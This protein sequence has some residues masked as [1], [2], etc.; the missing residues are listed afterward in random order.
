MSSRRTARYGR[1][2]LT[3]E[4]YRLLS[5]AAQVSWTSG[6]VGEFQG[7]VTVGGEHV[8]NSP[9]QAR[10]DDPLATECSMTTRPH[11]CRWRP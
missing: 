10:A 5:V 3:D 8:I 7:S 9:V 11:S 2:V 1:P 4:R 6:Q